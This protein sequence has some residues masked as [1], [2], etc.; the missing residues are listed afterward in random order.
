[1]ES[2]TSLGGKSLTF[3]IG[4][5]LFVLGLLVCLWPFVAPKPVAWLA[6]FAL[7]LGMILGLTT[8]FSPPGW[9]PKYTS[10]LLQATVVLLGFT[11]NLQLVLDAGA[12]GILLSLGS[13]VTVFGL[14]WLLKRVLK[15]E[16]VS[17]L[18]I[19]TG[20]AI[21]GGSAIAAMSTTIDA[22]EE[23]TA[24]SI[25]VVFLLN[26]AALLLFPPLGHLLN[27]SQAQFGIWSGIAIHDI[28]SVV[29]AGTVYGHQAL[30]IGTAVKLSR[31]LYMVPITLIAAYTVARAK[32]SNAEATGGERKTKVQLPWFIL[33]FLGASLLRTKVSFVADH[34]VFLSKVSVAGFAACLLLIGLSLTRARIK[35]VGVKPLILG[36]I[37]WLFISV[38]SLLVI[39]SQPGLTDRFKG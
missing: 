39:L 5:V 30:M 18:L 38:G 35:A 21:C 32:P 12:N 24:V 34:S 26:A 11:M 6:P 13:I 27:L 31:V 36:F 7:V 4:Q 37:L 14:G 15:T 23:A 19:S 25:A 9:K 17:S 2:K 20:T 3:R 28:A 29:G 22:R 1:M 33:L 16:S 8:G 10:K